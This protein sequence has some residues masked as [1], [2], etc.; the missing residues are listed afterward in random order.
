MM[1][2][3]DNPE[4]EPFSRLE[5][6]Q[7]TVDTED[8]EFITIIDGRI[9]ATTVE[10]GGHEKSIKSKFDIP[11]AATIYTLYVEGF[12]SASGDKK[13]ASGR[14]IFFVSN[15]RNHKPL[16]DQDKFIVRKDTAFYY[17]TEQSNEYQEAF[18]GDFAMISHDED[19]AST[20]STKTGHRAA[21][22]FLKP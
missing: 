13:T 15:T 16:T 10:P 4:L 8:H 5:N 20:A 12:V 21:G 6:F 22:L 2:T 3:T 18:F 17:Q 7:A 9:T 19:L 14:C 1:N 11:S